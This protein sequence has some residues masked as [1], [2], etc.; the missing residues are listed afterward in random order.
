MR[1]VGQAI[2]DHGLIGPGDRVLLG[3]SGS[4]GSLAL[5]RMLD[6]HRRRF[7]FQFELLPLG[8]RTGWRPDGAWPPK[9]L[10]GPDAPFVEW[11]DTSIRPRIERQARP[12]ISPCRRCRGLR[13]GVLIRV[14]EQRGCN[15]L[16]L[17]EDL[18]AVLRAL[19]GNL[20]FRGRLR[21]L[22]VEERLAR[23]Q[24]RLIRPLAYVETSLLESWQ[25]QHAVPTWSQACPHAAHRRTAETTAVERLLDQTAGHFPRVR[26]SMLA[27]L[28][29]VRV[30]HLLQAGSRK[31]GNISDQIRSVG[32]DV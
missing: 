1:R 23:S 28:K 20:L 24:V 8:L 22:P 27:A 10:G 13:T 31:S 30:S 19:L 4:L 9:G 26:R 16:A 17:G 25:R 2:G 7:R 32:S 12:G 18:D 15:K 14:A 21:A 5:L 3:V 11:L 6:L 29:H